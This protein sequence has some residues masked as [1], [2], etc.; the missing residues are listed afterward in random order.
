MFFL[1]PIVAHPAG[2]FVTQ[3]VIYVNILEGEGERLVLYEMVCFFIDVVEGV[4][5]VSHC[6]VLSDLASALSYCPVA[7]R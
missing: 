4:K 6:P 5:C 3:I 7:Q 2:R 1:L